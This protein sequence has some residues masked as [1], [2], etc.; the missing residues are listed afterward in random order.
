MTYD[1][2]YSNEIFIGDTV[3][4][5]WTIYASYGLLQDLTN[6]AVYMVFKSPSGVVAEMP[7]VVQSPPAGGQFYYLSVGD[8]NETG[9]W[10]VAPRI[11]IPGQIAKT[12]L[13]WVSFNVLD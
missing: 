12:A 2:K 4:F 5:L 10:L 11:V 13:P 6:A 9:P 7:G 8:F 3:P 1:V